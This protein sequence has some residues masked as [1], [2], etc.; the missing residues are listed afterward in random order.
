V[1]KRLISLLCLL[2]L[3]LPACGNANDNTSPTDTPEVDNGPTSSLATC[4]AQT[5]ELAD[6]AQPGDRITG[7]TED[8]A[9]TLI[10][11]GDFQ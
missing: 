8:Y 5:Q 9:V 1:K 7:A 2:I 4:T 11:Y 3:V 6:L 10:E